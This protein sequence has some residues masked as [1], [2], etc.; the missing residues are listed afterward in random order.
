MEKNTKYLLTGIF[1]ILFSFFLKFFSWD[2]LEAIGTKDL[3]PE[4]E[5]LLR[6]N[7]LTL[8][9]P[10]ISLISLS[11]FFLI[12]KKIRLAIISFLILIMIGYVYDYAGP[13]IK[14]MN[15]E[16]YDKIHYDLQRII[17]DS[18]YSSEEAYQIVEGLSNYFQEQKSEQF[19]FAGI[20]D[21]KYITEIKKVSENEA[22]ITLDTYCGSLCGQYEKYRAKRIYGIWTFELTDAAI[23]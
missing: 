10:F 4:H 16:K 19:Y 21:T 9:V 3:Y 5:M 6:I 12:R 13:I 20:R 8:I 1:I 18:G 22:E 7:L 17:S 23:S 15:F 2:L 11:I 14:K